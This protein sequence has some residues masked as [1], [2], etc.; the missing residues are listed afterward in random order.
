VLC[1]KCLCPGKCFKERCDDPSVSGNCQR[2]KGHE[3]GHCSY[4]I[5]DAM[6]AHI[7]EGERQSQVRGRS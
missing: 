5:D 7:A 4:D 1:L 6:E 3:G 2:G